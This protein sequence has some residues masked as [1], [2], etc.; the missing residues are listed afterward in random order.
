MPRRNTW[1]NENKER[2][3]KLASRLFQSEARKKVVQQL[4]EMGDRGETRTLLSSLD[5]VLSFFDNFPNVLDNKENN[6]L[7]SSLQ[8]NSRIG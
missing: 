3:A 2:L 5:K 6:A 4:S 8:K 1:N 7:A